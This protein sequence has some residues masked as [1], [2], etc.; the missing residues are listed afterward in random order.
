LFD[1]IGRR[2]QSS[3]QQGEDRLNIPTTAVATRQQRDC[4]IS[5]G[6]LTTVVTCGDGSNNVAIQLNSFSTT[7]NPP[8][9][10]PLLS[11]G[12]YRILIEQFFFC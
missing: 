4:E 8:P 11:N 12:M 3:F 5:P 6:E 9:S 1:N 7:N 10:S 2:L